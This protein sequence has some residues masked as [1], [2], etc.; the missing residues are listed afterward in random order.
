M[1]QTVAQ[2]EG[3]QHVAVHEQE[4]A[5]PGD[6]WTG[7]PLSR[8]AGDKNLLRILNESALDPSE[9]ASASS[10]DLPSLLT[11]ERIRRRS[12]I[13][14]VRP[15]ESSLPQ[16]EA[17]ELPVISE[18]GQSTSTA[19][20]DAGVRFHEDSIP[21][22]PKNG[23]PEIVPSL[24]SSVAPS[25]LAQSETDSTALAL[26][27]AEKAVFRRKSLTH[28]LALCW[29]VFCM[30]WNDGTTGPMLPRIQANYHLGFALVSLIF[31]FNTIGFI[32]GAMANIY[33]TDRFGMGKVMIIAYAML[34]PAG[35]FP[36]M[37]AAFVL[38]GFGLS[39]QNAHCNGFVA[40]LKRHAHTKMGFLHGSYGL[41]ALISPLVATQFAQ[42]RTHWSL[43]YVISAGL[44]VTAIT[45]LWIVFRGRRQQDILEAEGE[46]GSAAENAVDSNKY[47][48]VLGLK[49][50][51]ILSAFSLIYVGLEVTMGGWSVTYILDR[52][53][54][55]SNSG[56]IASGFFGGLMLGRILLL[57]LNKK[58]GE[59]LALFLYALLAIF[60]EVT[61]WVVPSLI[62][63]AVAVSCVG[64]LLGPMYPILMNHSTTILPRWL[65]TACMGY[66]A[67]IGLAGSAILP[68][69]TG[70]LA[71]KFGI[72]SLQPFVVSMMSTL[73]V[74]WAVIP[75][76][77]LVPT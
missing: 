10:L 15:L 2:N 22:A 8:L 72:A 25:I 1:S 71:S 61:V 57:W 6:A 45:V 7:A 73:I 60:V 43:H 4:R 52:R 56:Y 47:K 48:L 59:R 28:F 53:H 33:L 18:H 75:R 42:S 69:L 64:L 66:I 58:L 36:L 14:R 41:G 40:S 68:F 50:V 16:A 27:P 37:C 62:E 31:V 51:H 21:A 32:I 49:E 17:I 39:L 5:L 65:L 24:S 26:S 38:I 11:S 74:I 12:D 54:G 55:N 3:E 76:A 34:A 9:N 13:S 20:R 67:A 23:D 29:C 35:P 44:Y 70:L 77:R 63:N 46:T 19:L 30:G